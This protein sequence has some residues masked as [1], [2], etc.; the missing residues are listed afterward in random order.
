[1][2]AV[3]TAYFY[4]LIW[5]GCLSACLPIILAGVAYYQFAMKGGI[6]SFQTDNQTSL[7]MVEQYTEKVMRDIVDRSFQ[8]ALDPMVGESFNIRNYENDYVNQMELLSKISLEKYQNNL[9]GNIYY[10]NRSAGLV[11][12]NDAGHQN[13][14]DFKF[15][16]DIRELETN[17]QEGRW[18]YLPEG[19]RSGY[20]SFALTLPTLSAGEAQGLLVTQ[21][22]ISQIKKYF[23]NVSSLAKSQSIIVLDDQRRILFQMQKEGDTKAYLNDPVLSSIGSDKSRSSS[24]TFQNSAGETYFYS[25]KKSLTGNTY[26]SVIP[27]SFIIGE[28]AWIRWL[29][30]GAVLAL[31]S[32]GVLLT[33]ITLRSACNPIRQLVDMLNKQTKT[34]GEQLDRSV[35]PLTERLL[36]QWLSGNYI[37]GPTLYDECGKYGIPVDHTYVTLLVKVENLF[38]Q[39]RF[40]PEDKPMLTFAVTNVMEELLSSHPS[41]RGNVLHDTQGQAAAILHFDR[42]MSQA[43]MA[44]QTRLFAES[45]QTALHTYLKL[46]VSVGIGR[47]YPHLADIRVSYKESKQALQYRLYREDES[48]LYIEDLEANQKLPA[49]SYPRSI[50]T[51]IVEALAVG[52]VQQ[53]RSAMEQFTLALQSSESYAI[54]SQSYCMLLAS[55]IASVEHKGGGIPD[56]LEFDLFDQLRARE[57]RAEMCEWFTEQLFPL[58]EKMADDNYN[59]TGK[60]I[61]QKA[62]KHVLDHVSRDISLAECADLLHITPAYL[63]RLFKKEYGE[64]FLD[65]VTA[66]KMSEARRLL[67]ATDQNISQIA[68][69]VG[70]SHRTF[71]R[72]FQR[73]LKMSPS[74]YRTIYR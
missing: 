52:D 30:V 3:K 67:T 12:S 29:T 44:S 36:Q 56:M 69:A 43:A 62:R 35:P 66:C 32:V 2:N 72:V 55:I 26:I 48:I 17:G 39:D 51:A 4:R 42:N 11:L 59:K 21:V 20:I 23:A 50:E 28:L 24:F 53:A 13:I 49:F 38:K 45:V 7:T 25:F 46:Q 61:A 68:E 41:L 58:Y 74:D 37:N 73:T 63:S 71:N 64:S 27:Y 14:E 5:L 10:Y 15:K 22:D 8:L 65:Y 19:L 9:I 16:Q 6:A 70:Y 1:M 54:S 57:T 47:F 33:V 60:L 34:L 40:R 31:L 18:I